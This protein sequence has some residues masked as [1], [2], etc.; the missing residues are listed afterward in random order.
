MPVDTL[1]GSW[2]LGKLAHKG[3]HGFKFL[4]VAEVIIHSGYEVPCAH[5]VEIVILE[6]VVSDSAVLIDHRVGIGNT[7]IF[8]VIVAIAEVCVK[9]GLKLNAHHIAPF[10]ACREVK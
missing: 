7:I 2:L 10:G 8:Y 9:H 6:F 5:I 4:F 3:L 1:L